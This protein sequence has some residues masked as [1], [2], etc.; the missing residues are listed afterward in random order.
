MQT[1]EFRMHWTLRAI[2]LSSTAVLKE[3]TRMVPTMFS[4]KMGWKLNS[5]MIVLLHFSDTFGLSDLKNL[6][7][8]V[9]S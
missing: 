5:S 9:K 4:R 3:C 1:L 7:K 8:V 6:L 2:E